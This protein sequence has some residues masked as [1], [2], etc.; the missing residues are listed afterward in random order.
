MRFVSA[1]L[2]DDREADADHRRQVRRGRRP[3]PPPRRR[4]A[5]TSAC[6]RC[7]AA[8]SASP[9]AVVR[10]I[11]DAVDHHELPVG[12]EIAG[13]ARVHPAV[14]QVGGGRLGVLV[15]AENMLGWRVTISPTPFAS[16]SS[17]CISMSSPK[18]TPDVSKSTSSRPVQRVGAEQLRS[19][20]RAGA[21]ARPARGRTGTYPGPAPRRR[22]PPSA[23]A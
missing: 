15:V 1:H 9:R 21:A 18:P 2:R 13:I 19:G 5:R 10:E 11:P 17:M 6:S 4:R 22:S 3:A 8:R 16:G 12:V 20:R 23:A 7:I 14:A